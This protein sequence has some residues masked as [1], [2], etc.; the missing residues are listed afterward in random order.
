MNPFS[1][2]AL[3]RYWSDA[4]IGVSVI[5]LMNLFG[6]LIL[7]SIVGYERS[8]RSRAAGMRT[9]GLVCMGSAVLTVVCGYPHLWYGGYAAVLGFDGTTRVI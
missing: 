3:L 6:A 8:Y 9:L 2:E 7:G 5:V 1:V 4:E